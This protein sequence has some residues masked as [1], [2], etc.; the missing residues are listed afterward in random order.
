[1]HEQLTAIELA[2][3]R[4]A[5]RLNLYWRRLA[6]WFISRPDSD[7]TQRDQI[8]LWEA[9]GKD[10]DACPDCAILDHITPYQL[11]TITAYRKHIGVP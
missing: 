3:A 1:M 9:T 6:I 10:I 2:N 4:H 8:A 5:A 11:E 7:E